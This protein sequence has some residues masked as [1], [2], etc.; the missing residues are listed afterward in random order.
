[1]I[2][3]ILIIILVL[4]GFNSCSKSSVKE[5]SNITSVGHINEV[6]DVYVPDIQINNLELVN[7]DS[8]ISNIGSLKGLVLEDENL[9]HV[10]FFNKDETQELMLIL[11]PGSGYNDVY[12][13]KVKYNLVKIRD[14]DKILNDSNF[15]TES[16]IKLGITKSELIKIKGNSYLM[17]DNNNIIQYQITESDNQNFLQKYNLPIYYSKYTFVNDKLQDFEFGFEYP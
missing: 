17:S 7:P 16:G 10:S 9:P 1:M 15:K 8:V 3:K 5:K 14:S 11:F 13:F 4:F 12:Q 2:S 6:K